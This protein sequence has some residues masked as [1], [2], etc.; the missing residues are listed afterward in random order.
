MMVPRMLDN[1]FLGNKSFAMMPTFATQE[2]TRRD[3][4]FREA[5]APLLQSI[6]IATCN[7]SISLSLRSH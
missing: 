4:R 5:T 6:A 7:T 1:I 3:L 2:T